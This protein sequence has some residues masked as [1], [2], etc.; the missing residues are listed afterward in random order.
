[1]GLAFQVHVQLA[2]DVDRDPSEGAAG[3]R[4]RLLAGVVA[5]DRLGLDPALADLL[6]PVVQGQDAGGD[7][8]RIFAIL[9]RRTR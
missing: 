6:I 8:G 1:V 9:T 3:E 5:G 7:S 4:V 2:A